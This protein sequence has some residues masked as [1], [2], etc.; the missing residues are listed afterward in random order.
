MR[1]LRCL[2]R[3]FLLGLRLLSTLL[4]VVVAAESATYSISGTISPASLGSG[5]AV[6]LTSGAVPA[7]VQSAPGSNS[8]G[9]SSATVSF[10][11][12]SAAGDT[13]LLFARF[14][15]TTI[16]SVSDN[17]SGGSNTYTSA[18]GPTQWGV[19]PNV[20]DRWA[21]VFVAK[22]IAGGSTLTITVR[23]AGNS[24]YAIYLVVLEYSGVDPINP[25]NATGVGT[26]TTANGGGAP[27]SGNLTT[28][29]A[30]AKLVATSWD[31][32]D[33]YTAAGNG[34]GYTTNTAAGLASITGG[35]GWSNLTEDETAATAG[36][37]SA[38][39]TSA[40]AVNDWVIQ[41]VALAPPALQT[42]TADANGNYTFPSV[43]AGLYSVASV[44]SGSTF[45][46]ASQ[47]V[48]VDVANVT[49]VNFT[50]VV[51]SGAI[52]G[53]VTD[54]FGIGIANA[55]VSSGNGSTTSTSDGSYTLANIVSIP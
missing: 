19:A 50:A 33:S 11:S 2:S 18:V 27:A 5:A 55:T 54:S 4:C 30:N 31:S 24:S 47:S 14:G 1:R 39:A 45:T 8:S 51:L 37:W 53:K 49:G 16:S 36:T 15:G 20:T 12:A 43:T 42:V 7:L 13:I 3:F 34:T 44:K 46:P 25:I 38:G 48:S 40:R 6:T 21:Q 23:F 32:N 52:S 29:V 10:G 28:T 9:N 26:G 35:S 22:N 41:A 17:Q